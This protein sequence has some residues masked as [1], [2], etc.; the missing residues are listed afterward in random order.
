MQMHEASQPL[1]SP[2]KSGPKKDRIDDR[3]ALAIFDEVRRNPRQ[4]ADG[5]RTLWEIGHDFRVTGQ[6]VWEIYSGIWKGGELWQRRMKAEAEAD[7][8]LLAKWNKAAKR[9][10]RK[11]RNRGRRHHFYGPAT[12]H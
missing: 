4:Y 6:V 8:A 9:E 3:V 5:H 10:S 12:R 1:D 7:R 11:L 2:R